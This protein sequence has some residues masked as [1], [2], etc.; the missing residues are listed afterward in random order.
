MRHCSWFFCLFFSTS[1]FVLAIASVGFADQA[2]FMPPPAAVSVPVANTGAVLFA[3]LSTVDSSRANSTGI[4]SLMNGGEWRA[5]S[6]SEF[7]RL[8]VVFRQALQIS[9]VSIESCSGEFQ[10]GANFFFDPG[11]RYGYS[12]GG[13]K[14][15]SHAPGR[16]E[17]GVRSFTINFRH[18]V[19]PCVKNL[20]IEDKDGKPFSLTIP[21]PVAA[22]ITGFPKNVDRLFDS[23]TETTVEF[24][25]PGLAIGKAKPRVK[26]G[27]DDSSKAKM[28]KIKT[29]SQNSTLQPLVVVNFAEPQTIDR[30]FVWNGDQNSTRS[31]EAAP[32]LV[33]IGLSVG[34]EKSQTLSLKPLS[35]IQEIRLPKPVHGSR[36]TLK[37]LD[38]G[39]ISEIAFGGDGD[40]LVPT[41]PVQATEF[42]AAFEL[43]GIDK[44]ME[45]E[46]ST[47][48]EKDNWL[49]HFRADGTFF[50]YG[51][52]DSSRSARKFSA[53]GTFQILETEKNKVKLALSGGRRS[54]AAAW[55]G[56]VCELAC[57]E[58]EGRDIP[59]VSD[60]IL[61]EKNGSGYMIRNRT[62]PKKRTL[63]F[64]DMRTKI[65]TLVE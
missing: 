6:G 55:D 57:N 7:V 3:S 50:I 62:P 2:L 39:T 47:Q 10:D 23:K 49:F 60:V 59:R 53:L 12:E 21:R 27:I 52:D 14:T 40:I 54:T 28:A 29:E 64:S 20:V 45:H 15:L 11:L 25:V 22:T 16:D 31:F 56:Y 26:A 24:T 35:G 13:K 4:S 61:I 51:F 46:L 43:S 32:R 42:A 18:S 34:N 8:V 63:P 41:S 19:G 33:Q 58:P 38:S 17:R 48:D 36:I 44:V 5:A 65:S 1:S 30:V 9:R 37:P